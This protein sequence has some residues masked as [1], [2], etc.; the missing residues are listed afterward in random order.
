MPS[1]DQEGSTPGFII[2]TASNA[3]PACA[4]SYQNLPTD[5]KKAAQATWMSA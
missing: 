2:K 5:I 4:C 3:Y 1:S